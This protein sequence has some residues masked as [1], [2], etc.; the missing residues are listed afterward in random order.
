MAAP[1]VSTQ[2]GPLPRLAETVLTFLE[3]IG[4]RTEAE[5]YLRLFR[6]LPRESF[7]IIAAEAS[8]LD[9]ALGS[10]AE[11]LRYLKEL[12][13]SA[14]VA[15]GLWEPEHARAAAL[16]LGAALA[17]IGLESEVL[18][19]PS[20]CAA[21]VRRLIGES[22]VPVMVF[23]DATLAPA[24]RFE[25]VQRLALDLETRKLVFV[26]RRGGLG[27]HG[28][29][30]LELSKG[31]VLPCHPA[32]ISVVNLRTDLAALL[33]QS[34]LSEDDRELL[35]AAAQILDGAGSL[36]ISVT[37]PLA[38]LRELFTVKGAGTLVK[39]GSDVLRFGAYSELDRPRLAGLLESSFQGRIVPQ[40]FDRM[41]LAVYVES[42]Y[43]GAA[44]LEQSDLAPTLSKFA[45]DPVAQG[46]G[47]GR[48]IWQAMVRDFH[49]LIWR[50]RPS[51]PI[52]PWYVTQCDGMMRAGS[53]I[54]FWRNVG[55]DQVPF[56]VRELS[57][58]SIDIVRATD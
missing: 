56:I 8:L 51:N 43:R 39:A 15:I 1:T 55:A 2:I 21:V 52:V 57:G 17:A 54:V 45:V 28:T 19:A 10:I 11:Q 42:E 41:P 27:P 33:Q 48:D 32:G 35:L 29:N 38:L 24:R 46:E 49:S 36:G 53:W 16:R 31:H 26:R 37:S 18:S 34:V 25:L 44:I 50:A 7:A 47:V 23:D 58:R 30:R 13:L 9:H 5:L 20:A 12:G 22:R 40:F 4:K 3:S 6:Q 14:P